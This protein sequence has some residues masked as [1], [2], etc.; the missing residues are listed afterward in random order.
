M[1]TVKQGTFIPTAMVEKINTALGLKRQIAGVRFLF[2]PDEFT[3]A[4]ASVATARMPYCVMVK[5]AMRGHSVKA[6]FDNFGCRASARALGIMEPEPMFTSGRHYRNIGLYE[7]LAV[8]KNIRQNMTLCQ[9]QAHGVMVKPLASFKAACDVVLIVCQPY[10]A[11]R[12]VQAYTYHHGYHTAF[13]MAGNQ[14]LCSECT[15]HP[16]ENNTINMSMLCSGT[17]FM[18][19][20]QDDEMAIG[21][22]YNKLA[23]IV[24]GLF[25]TMNLTEP[26]KKKKRIEAR[27]AE[28]NISDIRIQ[29]GRNYYTGLYRTQD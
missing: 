19:G 13:R 27:L 4:N 24:D 21:F 11:M 2:D 25:A 23:A 15:A 14:A 20:W 6:V 18:G 9:H 29:Y 5:R 17:R 10:Q 3:A 8:A 1:E 16:F 12:L 26:D 22:P 28:Q 7:D